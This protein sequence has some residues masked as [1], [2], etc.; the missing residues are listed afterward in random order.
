MQADSWSSPLRSHATALRLLRREWALHL[1]QEITQCLA[2]FRCDTCAVKVVRPGW[3]SQGKQR[4]HN[5][6]SIAG[7]Y[8]KV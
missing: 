2:L 5:P 7:M 8:I 3:A 4:S 1:E 6:L